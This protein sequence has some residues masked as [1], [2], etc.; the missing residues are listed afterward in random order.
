VAEPIPS[1]L[2]GLRVPA[3]FVRRAVLAAGADGSLHVARFEPLA[4]GYLPGDPVT[5]VLCDGGVHHYFHFIEAL[6]WLL[7]LLGRYL[8]GAELERIVFAWPWD[9]AAQNHVQRSVLAA[10]CPGVEIVDPGWSWPRTYE[11]VLVI[12][13]SWHDSPL[14]K[15]LEA[16]LGIARPAALAMGALARHSVGA[17][18]SRHVGLRLLHATR[19]PPRCLSPDAEA[20]LMRVLSRFGTLTRCDFAAIP[21]EQQVRLVASHDVLVGVHGNGLTNALWMRPG[22]LVLELFPD[23]A[24]HYDYQ[25]IAELCDLDYFGFERGLVFP[26]FSRTGPPYGHQA[27]TNQPVTAIPE[28]ALAR[29]LESFAARRG[30]FASDQQ[31]RQ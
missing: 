3:R 20:D 30:R 1:Q 5:A 15:L 9:N 21:W 11:H 6:I 4:E 27:P 2:D 17:G 13:R 31:T 19:P 8:P 10:L 29:L 26:A 14:N 22:G 25:L 12:D 18:A 7:A 24:R 28:A 23:G 16:G